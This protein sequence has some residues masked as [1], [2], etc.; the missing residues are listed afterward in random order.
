MADLLPERSARQVNSRPHSAIAAVRT[1]R[2]NRRPTPQAAKAGPNMVPKRSVP[3]SEPAHERLDAQGDDYERKQHVTRAQ[4]LI[5]RPFEMRSFRRVSF[6][7]LP[8]PRKTIK[9]ALFAV[10]CMRLTS[11]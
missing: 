9:L 2:L 4:Q 6:G 8:V 7:H 10:V 1:V 3:T 5:R 11:P